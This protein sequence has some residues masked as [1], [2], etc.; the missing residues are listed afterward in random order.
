MNP[1]FSI[2]VLITL[3]FVSGCRSNATPESTPIDLSLPPTEQPTEVLPT[4]T[5][6]PPTSTIEP[7]WTD[8]PPT[9]TSEPT[10]TPQPTVLPNEIEDSKGVPMVLVPAGEFVMG[11][12]D[13]QA[14]AM[15]AHTVYLDEYY[16]DVYEVTQNR[17][18]ECL[19]AGG[20]DTENGKH[21]NTPVWDEHP[22]M[23]INWYD[24][25][26]Y[27]EW[28]GGSLPTEAQWEKAARGTDQRR[29]P[30]GNEPVSCE[31][32]RYGE[33][34]WMT[35]PVGSHP[36]GVSPYGV[37]DMAG[38]AWEFVYDWY[39][40]DYYKVSPSENPM[41]PD[42]DTGWKS[43][44]GGAWFYEATL[45]SSIWRNHAKPTWHFDYVGFRCIINP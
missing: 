32:A 33:C 27:C 28:R 5:E 18:R 17:Y 11:A 15:P 22:M 1:G 41:G 21:L 30:W 12:D 6:I 36:A 29:Y 26:E 14:A 31:L 43:E 9:K 37:H 4:Q 24:A 8:I 40:R 39:D 2:I 34:G 42:R 16:I 23:D 3:I 20:C 25:Q 10:P 44:R 13:D 7:T 38:N 19:E 35:A 45:M